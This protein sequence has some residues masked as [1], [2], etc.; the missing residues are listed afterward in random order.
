MVEV[1][2]AFVQGSKLVPVGVPV[3]VELGVWQGPPMDSADVIV[4]VRN[5]KTGR[6]RAF[7]GIRWTRERMKPGMH[8]GFEN[9]TF[10]ILP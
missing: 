5:P 10:N 2:L 3:T 8:V 6:E 7:Q 4:H 9:F 1:W